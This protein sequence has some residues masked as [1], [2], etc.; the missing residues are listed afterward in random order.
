MG[1][2]ARLAMARALEADLEALV[3]LSVALQRG[4]GSLPETDRVAVAEVCAAFAR[5]GGLAEVASGVDAP[6]IFDALLLEGLKRAFL[7]EAFAHIA[8]LDRLLDDEERLRSPASVYPLLGVQIALEMPLFAALERCVHA[9]DPPSAQA[10]L[11]VRE[12]LERGGALATALG[13][14][15]DPRVREAV[16]LGEA[17]GTLGERLLALPDV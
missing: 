6:R 12:V 4:V 5:H 2:R 11:A 3:P 9:A 13:P 14:D 17:D 1:L 10:L 15:V 7:G 8:R 16:A